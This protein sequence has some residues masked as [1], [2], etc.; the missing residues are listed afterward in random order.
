MYYYTKFA[1]GSQNSPQSAIIDTGS[2]TLAFPC[3]NCKGTACGSHQNPRFSTFH[4][5]SFIK[6]PNSFFHRSSSVCKFEKSYAEG[7]GL[8]GFLA[9]DYIKFKNGKRIS[10][11]KLSN[12]N[13]FL[14]K[15]LKLKAE[16]GCTTKESGLFK[17][18][19]ADGI[20]GLDDG[21]SF[22]KSLENKS[23]LNKEKVFSFGLCFH[24]TGGIMSIDLRNKN[25]PDDKITM[26]KE[27]KD[28]SKILEI[29][30]T[31]RRNYYE[32]KINGFGIENYKTHIGSTTMMIDSGTTFSHFPQTIFLQ[33]M[34]ILNLYCH[35][36]PKK[37]GRVQG[38]TF[39]EDSCL[40][41][42][43]PDA[44]FASAQ[45]LL[46][47]FP[48][49]HLYFHGSQKP[50]I[51]YPNNYFYREYSPDEED[52]T[53]LCMALKGHEEGRIILGAFSM[54]DYYFYFD[55]KQK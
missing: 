3:N 28:H 15:D 49:I 22:I 9:S 53:R 31:S 29:P 50:Y 36:H 39:N 17:D 20:L 42:H 33:I 19:Y 14:K 55:R 48:N 35:K 12:F 54:V 7:S 18:Q 46:N 11:N 16:F 21:S 51:L 4:S 44:H 25:Y 30:Y 8:N 24:K 37:C 2:D 45:D 26:L 40:E 5:K 41:L 34:K 47:S 6:C 38:G 10:D 13:K 43:Q 23:N 32:I 27:K 1:V 52:I